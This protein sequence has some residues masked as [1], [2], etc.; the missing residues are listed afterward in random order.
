MLRSETI[1]FADAF[2]KAYS[3]KHDLEVMTKYYIPLSMITDSLSIYDIFTK[4]L[5]TPD[6]RLAIDL[7]IVQDSYNKT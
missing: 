5:C 3:I 7:K 4:V 6:G 1:A 2:H